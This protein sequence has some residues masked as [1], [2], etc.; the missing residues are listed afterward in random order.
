MVVGDGCIS[1]AEGRHIEL[2]AVE[3]ALALVQAL[4]TAL[5]ELGRLGP[6]LLVE[7]GRRVDV[8][9]GDFIGVPCFF[10]S[11]LLLLILESVKGKSLNKMLPWTPLAF[12]GRRQR[13]QQKKKKKVPLGRVVERFCPPLTGRH[14]HSATGTPLDLND[15]VQLAKAQSA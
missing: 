1:L 2:R 6:D 14:P 11:F 10:C 13:Q 3:D 15:T 12:F 5:A 7:D 8:R 9:E 4:A